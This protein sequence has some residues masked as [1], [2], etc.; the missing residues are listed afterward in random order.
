LIVV[1]DR[2]IGT[3]LPDG[4]VD[5]TLSALASARLADEI[6]PTIGDEL[7]L[8]IKRTFMA[9]RIL[10]MVAPDPSG[11][12]RVVLGILSDGSTTLTETQAPAVIS[13]QEHLD[14]WFE[15]VVRRRLGETPTY[16]LNCIGDSWTW[17]G[18]SWVHWMA[19][20]LRSQYG[21]AGPGYI[22]FCPTSADTA[23]PPTSI[24][25]FAVAEDGSA[26]RT[27]TGWTKSSYDGKGPDLLQ[28][29][30]TT[31]GEKVT[32][33]LAVTCD[34][35]RIHYLRKVG[36]GELRWRIGAGSWTTIDTSAGADT[37]TTS[38]IAVTGQAAPFTLD[39]EVL[40][41]GANGVTLFGAEA[42]ATTP[43][44]RVN[45]LGHS[46][47][48]ASH[49]AGAVDVWDA[50]L[51]ALAG[52]GT[53]ISFGTNDQAAAITE[54]AFASACTTIAT[55]LRD[56]QAGHDLVF[57][58]PWENG[59][60]RATPIGIYDTGAYTAARANAAA[61]V[62]LPRLVG[63]SPAS[64][65]SDTPTPW[66]SYPGTADLLHPST[67]GNQLIAAWLLR[68]LDSLN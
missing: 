53:I 68:A 21:S 4:K 1:G 51:A 30:S 31:V 56:I 8:Q 27:G 3:V 64:Y 66:M 5:I 17:A 2:A 7:G 39:F 49:F 28:T 62:S 44:I 14:Q 9:G 38:S 36:G 46:G 63:A 11:N 20:R 58:S 10:E 6:A 40:T 19:K 13:G 33:T 67:R 47:A 42:L 16:V 23:I 22:S 24:G 55:R 52:Q 37:Y 54:A 57:L 65:G 45:R 26:V 48:R 61:M 29:T 15:F 60:E 25:D 50:A 12:L 34:T 41:A 32:L 18:A 35:I 59:A 43:G